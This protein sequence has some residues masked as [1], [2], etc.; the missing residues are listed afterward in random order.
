MLNLNLQPELT[1]HDKPIMTRIVLTSYLLLR[2][3]SPNFRHGRCPWSALANLCPKAL[4]ETAGV[5]TWVS[6]FVRAKTTYGRTP[7]WRNFHVQLQLLGKPGSFLPPPHTASIYLH[8]R[9]LLRRCGCRPRLGRGM[10]CWHRETLACASG[11][12]SLEMAG[13][14]EDLPVVPDAAILV[15]ER[16]R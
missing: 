16:V 10:P 4:E 3:S 14:L 9:T 2:H 5:E 12:T 15:Y 13:F 1:I 7:A 11:L 6:G 8:W